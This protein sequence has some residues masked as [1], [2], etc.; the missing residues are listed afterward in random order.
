[1]S[2][3]DSNPFADPQPNPF[4]PSQ[5]GISPPHYQP[6]VV[7]PE[8]PNQSAVMQPVIEPPPAY[9]PSSAPT[10]NTQELQRRQEELEKKAAELQAKEEALSNTPYNARANNWPPLPEKFCVGPCFYQDISVDIP[11][12][13]QKLVKSIYYVWM[14]YSCVLFLNM[15]GAL[16]LL[17]EYGKG[18]T[19]GFSLLAFTLFTPLSFLCW[20]RPLYK[21]FRSDSSFNFMVFFFV[22]FFQLVLAILYSVGIPNTGACGFVNGIATLQ[23]RPISISN[24]AVG[25]IVLIIGFLWGLVAL[26][27]GFMLMKVHNIYRNTGASFAKAQQE[28]A[29]GVLRNEHV[30]TAAVG[31]AQT[32]V[33]QSYG[34]GGRY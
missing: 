5:V 1:M 8:P 14:F 29:Q 9:S 34:G 7:K 3:F 19:F 10:I 16:A 32:A 6:E 26:L 13:F 15:L 11:L 18:S 25:G 24:Y 28:F 2:G 12:E 20:F 4:A 31:A 33:N 22:F 27:T 23:T 30:Q 17:V 21:A